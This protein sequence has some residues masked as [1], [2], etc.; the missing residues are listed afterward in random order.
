MT[1]KATAS[2]SSIKSRLPSVSIVTNS[3]TNTTP[4]DTNGK[5]YPMQ[6]YSMQSTASNPMATNMTVSN[7]PFGGCTT[8]VPASP[9]STTSNRPPHG[10]N[11]M[12]AYSSERNNN[13]QMANQSNAG[14]NQTHQINSMLSQSNHLPFAYNINNFHRNF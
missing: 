4:A 14:K 13:N 6:A 2:N 3:T 7:A 1:C 5:Q 9:S 8:A 11:N 12:H 10:L